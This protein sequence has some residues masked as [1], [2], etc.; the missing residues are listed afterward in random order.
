M[1]KPSN[2]VLLFYCS[3]VESLERPR[4]LN[5]GDIFTAQPRAQICDRFSTNKLKKAGNL[6]AERS[7]SSGEDSRS[8][9][10]GRSVPSVSCRIQ[11]LIRRPELQPDSRIQLIVLNG[12]FRSKSQRDR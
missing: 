10:L 11:I 9:N 12:R 6:A 1:L 4:Q 5:N 2:N 7:W 8:R 3:N